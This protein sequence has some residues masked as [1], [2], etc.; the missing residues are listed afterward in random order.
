MGKLSYPPQTGHTASALQSLKTAVVRN[1]GPLV[2]HVL[3]H[4]YIPRPGPR[5]HSEVCLPVALSWGLSSC[6]SAEALSSGRKHWRHF[7]STLTPCFSIPSP[8]T[9]L[10]NQPWVHKT[11][12]KRSTSHLC[13]DP[14]EWDNCTF[15]GLTSCL[16]YLSKWIKAQ[17]L[18]LCWITVFN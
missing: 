5:P 4:G 13:T 8:S 11:A 9:S 18:L 17:L 1:S 16:Y 7:F 14:P 10:L 12:V 2:E 15:W 3:K 6:T